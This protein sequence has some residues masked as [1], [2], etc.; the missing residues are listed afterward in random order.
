MNATWWLHHSSSTIQQL[1]ILPGS[2]PLL[3]VWS[4]PDRVDYYGLET[5]TPGLNGESQDGQRFKTLDFPQESERAGLAWQNFLETL[6]AP[7]ETALPVVI[8]PDVTIYTPRDAKLRV[9]HERAGSIYRQE[10]GVERKLELPAD[11]QTLTVAQDN[12]RVFALDSARLLYRDSATPTKIDLEINE[13]PPMLTV[14]HD[15][16]A[17]FASDRRR[18]VALH[19]ETPTPVISDLPY[20][21]SLLTCSPDGAQVISADIDTGVLRVFD[22]HTLKQTHQRWAI[23]LISSA[24][25]LQLIADLPPVTAS[26]SAL[27]AGH[28]GLLAFAVSGAICVSRVESMIRIPAP[29]V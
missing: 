14:S 5:G 8:T 21:I 19:G 28:D 2:P 16:G 24:K 25:C 20:P 22:G 9:Y 4:R 13:Q 1:D 12:G 6:H 18:I 17:V 11:V 27:T 10:G 15:G 3:A 29:Q 23:D 26:L 7:N